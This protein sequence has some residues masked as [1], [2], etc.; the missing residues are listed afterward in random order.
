MN[1]ILQVIK[2]GQTDGKAIQDSIAL[3]RM[4][5]FTLTVERYGGSLEGSQ[6]IGTGNPPGY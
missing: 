3:F 6:K 2:N 5:D 4:E 1:T